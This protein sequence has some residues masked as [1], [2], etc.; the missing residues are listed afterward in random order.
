MLVLLLSQSFSRQLCHSRIF[1]GFIQLARMAAGMHLIEG[2]ELLKKIAT[3]FNV[4]TNRLIFE[5]GKRDLPQG[6]QLKLAVEV[7]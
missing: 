2:F 6:L 5:D 1:R 4:T 3:V 7:S